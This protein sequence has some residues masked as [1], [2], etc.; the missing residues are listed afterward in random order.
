MIFRTGILILAFV[1]TGFSYFNTAGHS[2]EQDLS[3][4]NILAWADRTFE[5]YDGPRFEKF[6]T[7][8]SD[9]YF[10]LENQ[11][12]GLMEYREEYK[13]AFTAGEIAKSKPDFDASLA[14]LDR[15]IDSL[16]TILKTHPGKASYYEI[17][18]WANIMVNNGL[19]VYYVHHIKLDDK[20]EIL[21]AKITGSIG[22]ENDQIRIL[23]K[24]AK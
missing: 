11:V 1:S 5:Y 4:K 20:F 14:K 12:N 10:K 13:T 24:G 15:K 3:E 18:F 22:K 8:P 9:A 2:N 21:N 23:Y 16:S 19:T 7:V 17:D 6:M